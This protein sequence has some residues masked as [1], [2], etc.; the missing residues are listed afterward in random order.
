MP[1]EGTARPEA[2]TKR[3]TAGQDEVWQDYVRRIGTGDETALGQLYDESSSWVY[4]LALR[5]LGNQADAEEIVCD[6]YSQ[7]WRK[8]RTFDARRAGTCAW[9]VMLCRSRC[10]DR[11][12]AGGARRTAEVALPQADLQAL[13]D[14]SWPADL[15]ATRTAVREAMQ[16]LHA[17]QSELLRLAFF[18]GLTHTEIADALHLPLGTVK[19]RIRSAIEQL[20]HL[21][22][23]FSA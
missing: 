8:A 19:G 14:P 3:N 4:S 9:I 20:R 15:Q 17:D 7:I 5:M 22:G 10:I 23:E 2:L 13:A 6:V 16:T 18:S 1:E 21:L 12:R 11:M